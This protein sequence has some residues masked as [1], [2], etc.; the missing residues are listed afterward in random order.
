M[1]AIIE[2][3]ISDMMNNRDSTYKLGDIVSDE[4]N[5]DTDLKNQLEKEGL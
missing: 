2:R 3:M 5:N 1:P 4:K